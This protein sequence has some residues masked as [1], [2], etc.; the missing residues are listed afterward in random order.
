MKRD[1]NT[2]ESVGD[3]FDEFAEIKSARP[4]PEPRGLP[5]QRPY[6]PPQQDSDIGRTIFAAIGIGIGIILLILAIVAFVTAA[7]W[8]DLDRSGAAVGY[9]LVGFFLT[10]AGV[11]GIIATYNHNFRVLVRPPGP[12]H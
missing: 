10:I 7:R 1:E 2:Y 6:A 3:K 8:S 12:H 11:G 5:P 4:E 9:T